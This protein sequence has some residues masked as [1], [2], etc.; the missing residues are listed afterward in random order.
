MNKSIIPLYKGNVRIEGL[1]EYEANGSSYVQHSLCDIFSSNLRNRSAVKQFSAG[2]SQF[3]VD[4]F[5]SLLGGPNSLLGSPADVRNA[6][7][8]GCLDSQ[9]WWQQ[10]KVGAKWELVTRQ[11]TTSCRHTFADGG[12]ISLK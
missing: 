2:W 5:N 10:T 8:G 12:G 4:G 7:L 6:L 1:E 3:S 9:C 11:P